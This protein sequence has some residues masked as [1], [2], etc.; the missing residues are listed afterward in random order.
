MARTIATLLLFVAVEAFSQTPPAFDAASVKPNVNHEANGEGR[1]RSSVSATPGNLLVRNSSLS[2]YIQWAYNVKGYQVSGPPWIE[3][4]RYDVAAKAAGAAPETQ[5]R[6]ML[7]TLLKER[8]KLAFHR[9]TKELQGYALLVAKGGHKLRE[10]TTG[11][12]PSMKPI[13][14]A[15]TG[16]R[17]SM[18][19]LANLLM[20]P[21]R[22]PVVDRTGLAGRYDFTIDLGPYLQP[23]MS[24]EDMQAAMSE[25]L[26]QQLGLRLE[27]RKLPIE[28]LV[29]DHADKTPLE[30]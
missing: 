3:S 12:E 26:Q 1:P 22:M 13:R 15:F 24:P 11:G 6:L 17:V 25:G 30:N 28:I 23:A 4:E 29:V 21:M 2:E 18:D 27:A 10:S 16:E 5:L 19:Y 14:A 9:E 20:S 7:Q 8:F